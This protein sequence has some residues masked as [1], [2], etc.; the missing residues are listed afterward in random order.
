MNLT[1]KIGF[2][3]MLLAGGVHGNESFEL[4]LRG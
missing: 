3:L 1:T 4:P 2:I